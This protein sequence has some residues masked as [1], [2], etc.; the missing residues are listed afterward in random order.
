MAPDDPA[1]LAYYREVEDLFAALRGV[2]HVLSPKDFQL[3]RSWWRDEVPMSAIRTGVTEVF[4]RRTERDDAEP[5]VSLSYCRH[6]VAEHARRLTEMRVGATAP[7]GTDTLSAVESIERLAGRLAAAADS[8]RPS[9]PR[10]AEVIDRIRIEVDAAATVDTDFVE[11]HLFALE[12]TLLADCLDA[13]E[14]DDRR[15]L[16][17]RARADAEAVALTPEARDRTFR[18][19]RDRLLRALLDLPRLEITG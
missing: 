4:A 13:L 18:A 14:D 17:E 1:E 11:E 2:P 16:E 3:M 8:A 12:S 6:A 15:R 9:R 5:V 10:V 7:S 19:L